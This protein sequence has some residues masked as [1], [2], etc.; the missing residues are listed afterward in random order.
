[1]LLSIMF[2][3]GI[4][5]AIVSISQAVSGYLSD[6]F[7]KRKI[8]VWLG[9]FFG[10]A[11]RV[12]YAVSSVWLW[13][14][15][16]RVLDRAGK[17]RGAPRDAMIADASADSERGRNFGFL[18]TFDNL[19]AAL[20]VIFA[21]IFIN[22]LGYRN[23]FLIAAIPSLVASLIILFTI[24]D[25]KISETKIYKGLRLNNLDLNFKL[26][27]ILS[28]VFS[29]GSFSYSFLLIFAKNFGFISLMQTSVLYLLFTL[30][31]SF[32]SL[33]FGKLSDRLK[34]RKKILN[35]AF[36]LW[37]AVCAVCV[38]SKSWLAVVVAFVI[39]GLHLGAL[40][41]IQAAFV[42]ELSAPQYRASS[43]GGFRLV[44]GLCALPASMAAGFLWDHWGLRAP[45]YLSAAL[46][47]FA[48]IM[49]SF[50]KENESKNNIEL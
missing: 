19:G 45:F 31:A 15:P 37:L 46:T 39:Y 4:G 6:K 17:M 22:W 35:I 5:D 28:A 32:F 20:G 50:I 24:K 8:F 30:V 44:T 47:V 2:I 36:F 34:S 16:F 18:N 11:A 1:M 49:L 33:P 25:V 40:N 38:I 9:Y 27:L 26:F 42:S 7:G 48:I 21:I 13:L 43:L 23:L 29:L 12:G 41:T 10:A 3:D 14:I